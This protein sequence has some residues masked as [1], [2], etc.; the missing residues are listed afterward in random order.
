MKNADLDGDVAENGERFISYSD[1]LVASVSLEKD[2]VLKYFERAYEL[3]FNNN[4]EC[5][6]TQE[7]IDSLCKIKLLKRTFLKSFINDMNKDGN[8]TVD[9]Y[10]F[11]EAF[12]K[13]L[14][15]DKSLDM[16]LNTVK[17]F[18]VKKFPRYSFSKG[19]QVG[20]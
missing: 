18:M 4:S 20:E 14:G 13:N 15:L 16:N 7:L 12:I 17:D 9:Y 3:F 5:I 11:Y 2:D 8:D 10:E 1:F 6:D 19:A